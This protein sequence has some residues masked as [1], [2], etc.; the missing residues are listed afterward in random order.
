MEKISFRDTL[1][2][3]EMIYGIRFPSHILTYSHLIASEV[4]M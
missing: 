2:Q 1:Y 4:L 3:G